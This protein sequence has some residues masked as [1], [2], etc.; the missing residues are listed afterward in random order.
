M[1]KKALEVLKVIEYGNLV[2]APYCGK[3]LAGLGA[4]LIKVEKPGNGDEARSRGP[5]PN[6]IPNPERSGLFLSLNTNKLGITLNLDTVTGR[7]IL[8]R[9]LKEADVFVENNAPQCM[10]ELGLDYNALEKINPRLIMASI[11]PFGQSGPYKDY[12][13]YD[14]NCCAA[15]GISVGIG[16][17]DREPLTMPLS[18]GSYQSGATAAGAILV[19]LIAREKTGEGQ[20]IDIS[21]VEVW[22]TLHAVQSALTFLYRGVTGVRRGIHGGY[23]LYP[24]T[25]MP[26][27][28]GYVSFTAPQ[29]AQ[30]ERFLELIGNPKWTENP[31]YKDRRAMHE[32]YPDEVNKLLLPWFKAHTKEEIFQLCQ[33]RRIPCA[34]IYNIGELVNHPHLKERDFFVQIGHPQA[35][36]LKYPEGPCKFSKTNWQ[37]ERAAPLL[38]EHN[39]R[40]LCQR[41][42]Y[43][44]EELADLRRAGVV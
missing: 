5:F 38:G 33:Q 19:A 44:G 13:A 1:V 6:D 24:W 8:N 36:R 17:P 30:W 7:N 39:E 37:L 20:H 3:L 28:D 32:Q 21:E 34:P 22:A 29:L 23:F 16:Y 35:G 11:T 41:L 12:K 18:Q 31:R 14:I 40:I 43:S 9:L 25:I 10:K 15:G 42:G 26:C 4:E 27:K 2:S